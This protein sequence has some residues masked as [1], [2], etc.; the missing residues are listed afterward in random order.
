ME[1]N[2]L[3]G[4]GLVVPFEALAVLLQIE[5]GS[6]LRLDLVDIEVVDAGNFVAGLGTLYAFPLLFVALLG[7]FLGL[8]QLV[9]N[10]E[11]VMTTLVLPELLQGLALEF[12][13]LERLFL[14]GHLGC[15]ELV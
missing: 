13:E 15:Q 2:N 8:T 10:A 4:E 14:D 5:D 6:A 12:C 7:G 1:T 9:L 11:V 3:L